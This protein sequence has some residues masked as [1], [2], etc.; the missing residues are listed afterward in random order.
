MTPR[1]SLSPILRDIAD[2]EI[3]TSLFMDDY[4]LMNGQMGVTIF[5]ALLSRASGNHWY[6]EFADELL[7]N[8]CNNLSNQLPVDFAHGLC[9]IGWGIEFLKYRG[10]I[11]D[12]T[13]EILSEI[14]AAVMERDVRRIN[15][16]SLETGLQGICAYVYARINSRRKTSPNSIFD[17]KYIEE[18]HAAMARNNIADIS[19]LYSLDRVWMQYLEMLQ[20]TGDI[21]GW[22][23][24]VRMLE[25]DCVLSFDSDKYSVMCLRGFLDKSSDAGKMSV[26]VFT[27]DCAGG[28]YGIG[29]Y[30][31]NLIKCI[32][33]T[34]FDVIVVTLNASDL[35]FEITDG[36]AYVG[37]PKI[38]LCTDYSS[39][40]KYDMACFF[41]IA[42]KIGLNKKIVCHFNLYDNPL[43]CRLMKE[44]IDANTVFTVHFTNW[45][46]N[47]N[48]NADII[49]E[50]QLKSKDDLTSV[51]LSAL[52]QFQAEKSTL[53]E[54]NHIIVPAKHS[55]ENL[56]H[57]YGISTDRI[58][59]LPHYLESPP[60]ISSSKSEL[61]DKYEFKHSDKIVL[62]VGRLDADK[63]VFDLVKAVKSLMRYDHDINLLIAGDGFFNEL[64]LCLA[65]YWSRIRCVGFQSRQIISELMALSDLGVVPSH[66]EEFGYVAREMAV[67]G[68]P[69][70]VSDRGGLLDF[71]DSCANVYT[72]SYD[73]SEGLTF[74][75]NKILHHIDLKNI[76][77]NKKAM[78][79]YINNHSNFVSKMSAIYSGKTILT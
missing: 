74:M 24:G 36:V 47:F 69:V 48:G 20:P 44:K 25:S 55:V 30:V 43:L 64:C 23:Y 16:A 71:A 66:Y 27:S 12:D 7:E 79:M 68:L 39:K 42:E 6:E 37:I 67:A 13:D 62:F 63:G 22:Q 49:S 41:F 18:L 57:V 77:N 73:D 17:E 72:F 31:N 9:G 19:S 28:R 2:K 8:V 78:A 14:D 1:H 34:R 76:P 26:F 10:F 61:R 75:L 38:G 56:K 53:A 51:E 11:E 21:H 29:T 52:E 33:K 60:S 40:Q 54:C 46:I 32:D 3:L 5:F 58:H 35:I 70:L 65:P 15:D 4:S 45:G 59:L 50:I